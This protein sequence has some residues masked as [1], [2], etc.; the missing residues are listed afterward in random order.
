MSM[1]HPANLDRDQRQPILGRAPTSSSMSSCT[2]S[3][4]TGPPTGRRPLLSKPRIRQ[5]PTAMGL[6]A[7][8]LSTSTCP[9]QRCNISRFQT[10]GA[11]VRESAIRRFLHESTTALQC[12]PRRRCRALAALD[13]LYNHA[14]FSAPV[15]NHAVARINSGKLEFLDAQFTGSKSWRFNPP[16]RRALRVRP[17]QSRPHPFPPRRL[18]SNFLSP[19]R[20]YP[21]SAVLN[22][23]F[24]RPRP[25]LLH[26]RRCQATRHCRYLLW[27]RR[28]GP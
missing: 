16:Q 15:K 9:R 2:M 4:P 8:T 12:C 7:A 22:I 13:A 20:Q 21:R 25:P 6:V 1:H 24:G 10:S 5:R 3:R 28:D 27:P 14:R 11:G 19:Y 23:D 26:D 18:D 17:P